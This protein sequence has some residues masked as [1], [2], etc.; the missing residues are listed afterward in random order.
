MFLVTVIIPVARLHF[1]LLPRAVESVRQQYL[2]TPRI[3]IVNDADEPLPEAYADC[4][5]LAT[6]GRRGSAHARNLALQQVA[7]PFVSFLDADDIMLD[8]TLDLYLRA[9]AEYNQAGYIYGDWYEVKMDERKFIHHQTVAYDRQ[10]ML[11]QSQHTVTTLIPTENILR[12]GGFDETYR[13][14]EDWEM[15]LRL[16]AHGCCGVHVPHPTIVYD[17]MTSINR[18]AHYQIRNEVYHEVRTKYDAYIKGAKEF[19]P[20]SSCGGSNPSQRIAQQRSTVLSSMIPEVQAGRVLLEYTGENVGPRPYRVHGRR[21]V[22]A[23]EA[24]HRYVQAAPEDVAVLLS[25]GVWR[26]V[27]MPAK[28]VTLPTSQSFRDWRETQRV[29]TQQIRAAVAEQPVAQ[30]AEAVPVNFALEQTIITPK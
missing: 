8:T 22:G 17:L 26:K 30:P 13:G 23:N 4:Q 29:D 11:R 28:Q 12:I 14:W 6:G 1:A 9:F 18:N 10:K 21:Y 2:E 5:V 15:Y 27:V 16:G 3:I 24:H 25:F 20:C 19:M 7:T